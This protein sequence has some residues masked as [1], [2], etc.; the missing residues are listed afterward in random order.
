[1]CPTL[2]MAFDH[3]RFAMHRDNHQEAYSLDGDIRAN[4][5]EVVLLAHAQNRFLFS[6]NRRERS[7][8]SS[9]NPGALYQ[10]RLPGILWMRAENGLVRIFRPGVLEQQP[11][12]RP[13]GSFPR[14]RDADVRQRPAALPPAAGQIVVWFQKT[15]KGEPWHR[16]S[17]LRSAMALAT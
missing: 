9:L 3:A 5:A 8:R 12:W 14:P 7:P 4:N 2:S 17:R 16:T 10:R 1:M 15:G 6:T 13:A 11:L